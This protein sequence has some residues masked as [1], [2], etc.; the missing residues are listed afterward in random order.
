MCRTL[1]IDPHP[2]LDK[3]PTTKKVSLTVEARAANAPFDKSTYSAS[4]ASSMKLGT[5][6]VLIVLALLVGVALILLVPSTEDTQPAGETAVEEVVPHFPL[7]SA[8]QPVEEVISPITGTVQSGVS[9]LTAASAPVATI[10]APASKLPATSAAISTAP[11]PSTPVVT[12]VAPTA[13]PPVVPV[14]PASKV[15]SPQLP[16]TTPT[17]AQPVP[18]P[19]QDAVSSPTA[20]SGKQVVVF[21]V[22]GPSWVEVTDAKGVVQL[23]RNLNEG[24]EAGAAG[25]LPMV[26]VVGRADVTDVAVR[27]KPFDLSKLT[28]GNVARFEV[29]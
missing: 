4:D 25:T 15:S 13:V 12:T 6:A 5:T 7:E 22:R 20:A 24:E 21:K 11:L 17:N 2:I 28:V 18:L 19:K 23:R 9:P 8:K 3:L 16:A 29:K 27:G 10:S 14:V 1:K 26:V